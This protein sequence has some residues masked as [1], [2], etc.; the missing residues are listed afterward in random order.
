MFIKIIYLNEIKSEAKRNKN[1]N[2]F[3]YNRMFLIHIFAIFAWNK[4]LLSIN[5]QS[6]GGETQN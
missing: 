4:Y 5:F 1:P 2:S 6:P 3:H